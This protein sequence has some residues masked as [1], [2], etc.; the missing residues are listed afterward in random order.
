MPSG[1]LDEF[2][3]LFAM[4]DFAAHPPFLPANLPTSLTR[5]LCSHAA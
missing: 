2:E 4:A 3:R 5:L 1:A